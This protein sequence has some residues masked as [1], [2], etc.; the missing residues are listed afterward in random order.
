MLVVSAAA[1]C[2]LV[3]AEPSANRS[4]FVWNAS[5]SAPIGL[6]RVWHAGEISRGDLVLAVPNSVTAKLAAQRGYLPLGVPLIKR[7]AATEGDTICAHGATVSIDGA[8]TATRLSVDRH[9]RKLPGWTG[10]RV[11][12]RNDVFLL[13]ANVP[14]SFDGRYFGPTSRAHIAGRLEALW[15]R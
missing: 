11:L 8:V 15:T 2:A 10:C 9:G 14:D 13:M 3:A 12:G 5:A 7:I 4:L 6:Y 1:I